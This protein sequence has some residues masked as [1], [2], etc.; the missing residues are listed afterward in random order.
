MRDNGDKMSPF[1]NDFR[2][3]VVGE[4]FPFTNTA[5]PFTTFSLLLT[6]A[7]DDVVIMVRGGGG[8]GDGS[9]KGGARFGRASHRM[10]NSMSFCR[11]TSFR[12]RCFNFVPRKDFTAKPSE[13]KGK[14]T[15]KKRKLKF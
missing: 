1:S 8:D 7:G 4:T 6:M 14:P 12:V 9:C 11:P 15:L 10:E 5:D 2:L 13:T 3:A